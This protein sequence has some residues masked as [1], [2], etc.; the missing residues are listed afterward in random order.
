MIPE[1]LIDRTNHRVLNIFFRRYYFARMK[2]EKESDSKRA[3]FTTCTT[4][5]SIFRSQFGVTFGRS[6]ASL[7]HCNNELSRERPD[8]FAKLPEARARTKRQANTQSRLILAEIARKRKIDCLYLSI[9]KLFFPFAKDK[10]LPQERLSI[11]CQPRSVNDVLLVNWN[12]S[13]CLPI[14]FYLQK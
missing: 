8:G 5:Q 2:L 9:G 14:K 12:T 13:S 3:M 7:F 11:F 6:R 4:C 10:L 1:T